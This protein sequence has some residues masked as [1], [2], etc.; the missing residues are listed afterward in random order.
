[1]SSSPSDVRAD[2]VRAVARAFSAIAHVDKEQLIKL[3][4]V[5]AQ[6][7]SEDD[8]RR[9]LL[10]RIAGDRRSLA[11]EPVPPTILDNVELRTSLAR[12]YMVLLGEGQGT[13]AEA[14]P[15]LGGFT[16]DYLRVAKLAEKQVEVLQQ[17]VSMENRVLAAMGAGEEWMADEKDWRELASRST[18]VS[19]PLA[20]LYAAGTVGFSAVGIT[21]G[22]AAIGG[23]ALGAAL[24]ALGLN[25]MTAGIAVLI[26]IGIGIKKIA[27]YSFGVDRKKREAA[28]ERERRIK[29]LTESIVMLAADRATL[30]ASN[31]DETGAH[32]TERAEV[33]AAMDESLAA[34]RK[35]TA[36]IR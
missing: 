34:L 19:L 14:P 7:T 18:A 32:A 5:F 36:H 25:P 27:D 22:L 8:T 10:A 24:V 9:A 23:S 12:D 16:L 13:G 1:M 3:Y 26:G 20:V 11:D 15:S 6:M 4:Q 2:Y 35:L 31:E 17:W 33:L 28:A 29:V 21:S 30:A